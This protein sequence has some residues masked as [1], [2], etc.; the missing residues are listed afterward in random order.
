MAWKRPSIECS[1]PAAAFDYE[2]CGEAQDGCLGL[3]A[4]IQEL[5]R[6]GIATAGSHNLGHGVGW[7][8]SSRSSGISCTRTMDAIPLG[9]TEAA[10]RCA[11]PDMPGVGFGTFKSFTPYQ[12]H[13][14]HEICREPSDTRRI[15]AMAR[16]QGDGCL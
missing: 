11:E 10:I 13:V 12:T 7:H 14:L 5:T 9:P 3:T 1:V 6:V 8:W 2:G 4:N 16:D 15:L